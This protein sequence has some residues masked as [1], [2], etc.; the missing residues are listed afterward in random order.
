MTQPSFRFFRSVAGRDRGVFLT[1]AC[2]LILASFVTGCGSSDGGGTTEDP[3]TGT[4]DSTA[5]PDTLKGDTAKTDTATSI[6]TAVGDTATTDGGTDTAKIDG[7]TDG[8]SDAGSDATPDA[9]VDGSTDGGVDA[10]SDVATDAAGDAVLPEVG[11]DVGVDAAPEVATDVGTDAAIAPFGTKLAGGD[12]NLLAITT[13]GYAIV[14]VKTGTKPVQAIPLAGGAAV[15]IDATSEDVLVS[16]K[17]VFSWHGLDADGIGALVTW[18]AAGGPKATATKTFDGIAAASADGATVTYIDSAAASGKGNYVVSAPDGS[19]KK[20]LDGVDLS[21]CNID[22]RYAGARPIAQYCKSAASPLIASFDPTSGVK[23]TLLA[24]SAK[25]FDVDAAGAKVITITAGGALATIPAIGGTAT[26]ID[27]GVAIG[28]ITPDGTSV[29]YRMTAESLKR[30][31]LTTPAPTTLVATNVTAFLDLSP[32]GA[33][34]LYRN[35]RASATGL[36]DLF[37][38]SATTPGTP[39]TLNAA[40]TTDSLNFGSNFTTDLSRV[41]FATD[42]VTATGVA[43]LKV[44]PVSGGSVATVSTAAWWALAG[45]GSKIVFDDGFVAAAGTAPARGDIKVADTATG[46]APTLLQTKADALFQLSPAR[47]KVVYTY[48]FVAADK[49]LYVGT[50]P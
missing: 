3:D 10:S 22:M 15:T 18:T 43:A 23:A 1:S 19:G 14:Q 31:S 8:G 37:L 34:V 4:S 9:V 50:L 27:T 21:V 11:T 40:T 26:P 38:A 36:T 12:F 28:A 16:G 44:K 24:S 41:I 48:S 13:D 33:W 35:T 6:D 17:T 29:V 7:A 46:A 20:T 5:T 32:D 49:G 42:V 25:I 2:A 39:T 30:S 47:D 45:T